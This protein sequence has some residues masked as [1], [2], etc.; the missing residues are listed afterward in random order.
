MELEPYLGPSLTKG[1]HCQPSKVNPYEKD[2]VLELEFQPLKFHVKN[3]RAKAAR[4][5]KEAEMLEGK[6]VQIEAESSSL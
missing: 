6:D 1:V 2:L 3:L 4:L 5:M